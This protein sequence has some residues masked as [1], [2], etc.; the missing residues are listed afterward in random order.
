LRVIDAP[1]GFENTFL[2]QK[3]I[4]NREEHPL[5]KTIEDNSMKIKGKIMEI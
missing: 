4:I 2:S 3:K 5:A 1:R